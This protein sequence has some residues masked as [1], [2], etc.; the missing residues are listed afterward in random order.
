MINDMLLSSFSFLPLLE[1][2]KW[3]KV[4]KSQI[5]KSQNHK[6]GICFLNFFA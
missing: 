6:L 1:L 3:Q 4:T 2:K 5:T